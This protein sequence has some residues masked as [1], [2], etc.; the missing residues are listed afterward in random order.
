MRPWRVSRAGVAPLWA[1]R[2]CRLRGQVISQGVKL[3]L[4]AFVLE[5]LCSVGAEVLELLRPHTFVF[6]GCL[7]PSFRQHAPSSAV[8]DSSPESL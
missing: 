7:K 6:V 8:H 4:A 5:M 2:S 3:G 1:A